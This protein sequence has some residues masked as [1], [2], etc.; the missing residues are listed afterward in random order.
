MRSHTVSRAPISRLTPDPAL[1]LTQEQ[2]EQ[3]AR[4]GWSNQDPN[5]LPKSGWEI[6]RDNLCTFFNL[7]FLLFALCLFAVGAYR[8]MLFLSIV[9]FN[10]LIG[11]VQ[12]FRV[13]R[14]LD[15]ISLI[16][17]PTAQVVRDGVRKTVPAQELV[18][19][20]IV[21]LEAGG[22]VCADGVVVSG[23]A[24]VNEA[25][26]TGEAD[27][28]VKR[29]G[30]RLLSGSYLASGACT[31][32]LDQVGGD[33]YASRIAAEAKRRKTSRSGMMRSLDRLLRFLGVAVVPLGCV[34]LYKQTMLLDLGLSYSV[35]STVAAMVGMIPEGLYLLVSVALAVSVI[36]LSRSRT[37][38]H[39]LAC[40]ENLARVDV[41][42]LDK[43]G[44]L[45]EGALELTQLLPRSGVTEEAFSCLLASYVRAAGAG[46]ATARAVAAALDGRARDWQV[47]EATA[48][49]SERKWSALT[50]ADGRQ[51]RLGAPE[52]L[53]EPQALAGDS[54]FSVL[55]A[56][57]LRVLALA[58]VREGNPFLLGYAVLADRLRSDAAETLRYFREQGVT[59]KIISGDNAEAVSQVARRAGVERAERWMD[60]SGLEEDGDLSAL[61]EGNTVFGRV[62]PRQK[63]AL[64]RGLQARG[65][66]VAMLGDGVN[67][68]LA[69]K[70]ADCSVAMAAGSE[71][72]QQVSQLVL[73]DSD[74]AALPKIVLEGRR[75]INNIQRSAALFLYK[76]IFSFL[77]SLALLFASAAYPLLPAQISLISAVMIGAPSFLLTFE[78]SYQR[79]RGRFLPSVLLGALPGGVTC[80]ACLLA[81]LWAGEVLRLPLEQL[82]TVCALLTGLVG[83]GVLL[84][85]CWPLNWFRG[86]LVAA[87]GAG[88]VGGVALLGPLF[89]F[90]ALTAQSWGLFL[91]LA[92]AAVPLLALLIFAV[93][94]IKLRLWRAARNPSAPARMFS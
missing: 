33:A 76:N 16:S 6:V 88:F 17:A 10:V 12:E 64:I 18:L 93:S 40:I 84:V 30:D 91:A 26:L 52:C 86:L 25:L 78:P 20:D 50:L 35:S 92:A 57:G 5:Q 70:E 56:Q 61:A 54:Q 59:V 7:L 19:D 11:I 1:G 28:V 90:A 15:R 79:I 47:A 34:M 94:R 60:L 89:G 63:R 67:D 24:E 39:E 53:L 81:A 42:C 85:L 13:K 14:T 32:R 45:T 44:T 87:M 27:L 71:A 75:V 46:N 55:L 4:A 65:H 62:T 37:L 73:L 80:A 2:A 66:T 49:S 51:Y 29:A 31:A 48:F 77:V 38:V 74:F 82:S 43:T 58:E 8:D 36:S 72:A 9:V 69:L 83:F 23:T 22:Q 41:L 3:R 21:V 68:V